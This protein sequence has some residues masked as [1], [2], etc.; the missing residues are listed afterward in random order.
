MVPRARRHSWAG[1]ARA[2]GV[3]R[4]TTSDRRRPCASDSTR[5]S[6]CACERASARESVCWEYQ[7]RAQA[8][9]TT[10]RH[11]RVLHT[12]AVRITCCPCTCCHSAVTS[13][14]HKG[15]AAPAALSAQTTTN[16]Y[17]PS[18]ES[19]SRVTSR[20]HA[21][22][23]ERRRLSFCERRVSLDEAAAQDVAARPKPTPCA[24]FCKGGS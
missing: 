11:V 16:N 6:A 10:M 18:C 7:E 3:P 22:D 2:C 4:T 23:Y 12:R 21:P 14:V 20:R 17:P 8:M 5:A 24:V 9:N 19:S 13:F 15:G 1:R